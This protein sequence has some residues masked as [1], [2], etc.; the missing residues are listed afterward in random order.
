MCGRFSLEATAEAIAE[1]FG[2]EA[3]E[4][5]REA[6]HGF[7][8]PRREVRPTELVAAVVHDGGSRRLVALRW[9]LIPPWSRDEKIG[10]RLINA[11]AETLAEKPS[12][13]TPL[14]R[15]RCLIPADGFYEW[16]DAPHPGGRKRQVRFALDDGSLFAMAG[17]YDTWVSPEGRT[18]HSCAI[19]TVDANERVRP[20]HGRMPAVLRPEDEAVWLDPRER[21]VGRLLALLK[22]YDAERMAGPY[23]V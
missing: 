4:D 1:R 23:P 16:E 3:V 20:V 17:L 21:D 11:R 10:S 19:V 13:R 6:A 5:V 22:P 14:L 18:I 7:A 12:F 8:G 15:K 2:V 9:G